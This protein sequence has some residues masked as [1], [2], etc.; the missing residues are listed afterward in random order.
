MHKIEDRIVTSLKKGFIHKEYEIDEALRTRILINDPKKNISV[1]DTIKTELSKCNNFI[2][3]VAFITESGLNELK[4]LFNDLRIKGIKGRLITSN[5]LYFNTPKIYRELLKIKNLE[6]R[7]TDSIG[8]HAKGYLFEH[9]NYTT[10]L[11]GSSNLTS[12]ALKINHEWNIKISSLYE[13]EVVDTLKN[14]I[15]DTWDTAVELSDYWISRYEL[16]FPEEKNLFSRNDYLIQDNSYQEIT[17]NKMQLAALDGISEIRKYKQKRGL[18]VSATGTGKTYLAAFDVKNFKPKRLLFIVH[19]EQ[20]LHQAIADFQRVLNNDPNEYGILSGNYKDTNKKYLFSTIQSISMDKHLTN[21]DRSAFDYIIIDEVHKAGAKSYLKTLNYFKPEFLLGMSA[22]P[23]RTDNFN[24]F[25]LFD[26]NIAYEIRLQAALEEKMLCPFHYFGVSDYEHNGEI[27]SET[28]NLKYLVSEE[29]IN[30]LTEKMSYYGHNG[31]QVRG[32][33]FTSRKK[34]AAEISNLLNKKGY[35][36]TYL[37]GEHSHDLREEA[38]KKLENDELEYI[39]TVDVFNEGIDIPSVNQIVMLRETKSS[40]IFIQQ[41]GRGLRLDDSKDF[42]T[43]IDFIGNY[44]NNYLIPTALAGDTSFNKDELRRNMLDTSYI[45]GISSINFERVAKE[46]I[47][48]SIRNEKIDSVR[49]LRKEYGKMKNRLGRIPML[50]DFLNEKSID[51]TI[52]A[53]NQKNYYNFIIKYDIKSFKEVYNKISD[54][55]ILLLNMLTREFL[56][57]K[58]IH[59]IILLNE[60]IKNNKISIKELLAIYKLLNLYVTE[61]TLNSVVSMLDMSFYT[62]ST[63]KTY[64]KYKLVDVVDDTIHISNEFKK[65]IKDKTVLIFIEDILKTSLKSNKKY[66]A[67]EALTNGEIY[68]RRD[69]CRLFEFN[70]DI[71]GAMF[72]Y[73]IRDNICPVFVTYNKDDVESSIDYKDGFINTKTFRWYSRSRLTTKSAEVMKILNAAESGLQL[74]LFVKKDDATYKTN[75]YYLGEM[76]PI[77][78]SERDEQMTDGQSVVKI[79]MHLKDEIDEKFYMYLTDV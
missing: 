36:T 66:N 3:S 4:T 41:L 67:A 27:I 64:P 48:N 31:D 55:D 54:D 42:V 26:Y 11:M 60:L 22:T 38:I 33:I 13:G 78:N 32:L 21:F 30:Y 50:I 79:D 9:S 71:S 14:I 74:H 15:E 76:T 56:N 1:L 16:T 6:V 69:T 65:V 29:R 24:V 7:I 51:P 53:L 40:I 8:Y 59:E 12:S 49:N 58:R 44:R 52:I 23:E 20:I 75:F 43:V 37:T 47:F 46:R 34:E 25:E 73:I 17:P 57:G 5:Y 39:V 68:T 70:K 61:K 10:L 28:T 63:K 18:V 19:R 62:V 72:G 77:K 45:S 2:F 35:K